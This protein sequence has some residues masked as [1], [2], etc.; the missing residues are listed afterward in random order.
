MSINP[1]PNPLLCVVGGSL[2]GLVPVPNFSF[3]QAFFLT[4]EACKSIVKIM[5]QIVIT[6]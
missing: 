5:I 2:L 6:N 3:V 4:C 1:S